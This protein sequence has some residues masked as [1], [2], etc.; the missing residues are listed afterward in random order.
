MTISSSG[1]TVIKKSDGVLFRVPLA[2][3]S[4]FS[5]VELTERFVGGDGLVLV[6]EKDLVLIANQA[7]GI[8]SNAAF[9]LSS[10]NGWATAKLRGVQELG[11]VYPTTGVL[12]DGKIYVI[13]SK[14]NELIQAPPEQKAGLRAEATIQQIGR[15][16]R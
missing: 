9:S 8:A 6:E 10:E 2:R 3:P 11:D 15:T 13:S 12:R 16:A 14:L 7:S 1:V 4:E 5:K